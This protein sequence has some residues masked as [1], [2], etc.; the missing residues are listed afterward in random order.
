MV[1]NT[2]VYINLYFWKRIGKLLIC[3]YFCFKDFIY[4]FLD[5]GE[6]RKREGERNINVWLPLTRPLLGTWPASQACALTDNR[7]GDCLVRRLALS[8][9]SHTSHGSPNIFFV[10]VCVLPDSSIAKPLWLTF[11]Y[12]L[13]GLLFF[14][15]HF[16]TFNLFVS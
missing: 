13:R 1:L 8:P 11:D 5:R 9:L 12:C 6:G 16:C 15:F 4:L 14:P 2:T 7:T 10:F 3:L